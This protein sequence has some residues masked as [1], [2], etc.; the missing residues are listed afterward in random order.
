MTVQ[1]YD[2]IGVAWRVTASRGETAVFF[3]P[4]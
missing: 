3:Q 4:V 1:Q 2:E